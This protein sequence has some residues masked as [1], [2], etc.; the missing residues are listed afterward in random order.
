MSC[1][2]VALPWSMTLSD[3]KEPVSNVKDILM[4]SKNNRETDD[5]DPGCRV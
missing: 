3:Y 5:R 4:V 2:S 1:R